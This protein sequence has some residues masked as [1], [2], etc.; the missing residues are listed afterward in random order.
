MIGSE[1]KFE[2]FRTAVLSILSLGALTLS[3]L[4]SINTRKKDIGIFYALGAKKEKH[5]FYVV[6]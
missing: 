1:L 4:Y 2:I 5:N 3:L 6:F